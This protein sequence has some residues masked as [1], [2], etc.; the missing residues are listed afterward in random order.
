MIT[1]LQ[2][3]ELS[4]QIYRPITIFPTLIAALAGTFVLQ[5][6]NSVK[7]ERET[8]VRRISEKPIGWRTILPQNNP[9]IQKS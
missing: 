8:R 5:G 6:P 4:E 7:T 2:N 1:I 3:R 9:K